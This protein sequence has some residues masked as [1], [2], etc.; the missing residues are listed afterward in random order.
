MQIHIL[1][2]KPGQDLRQSLINYV[3]EKQLK[4]GFVVTCVGS[5]QRVAIR[6]ADQPGTM[7]YNR[8][9]EIVSLSGTLSVEHTHLKLAVSD[10]TGAVIGGHLQDGCTIYTT[11]EIVIGAADD[12]V[13]RRTLDEDTGFP[14]LVVDKVTPHE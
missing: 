1:R 5:L 14:E 2:L 6:M 3:T 4:A 9:F 8:K 13:F 10:D 11:A 12:V 7:A